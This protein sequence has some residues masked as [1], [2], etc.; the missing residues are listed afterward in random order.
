[1]AISNQLVQNQN[2]GART[3]S[4]YLTGEKVQKSLVSTLGS[5]K[6]MQK[7]VSSI[8]AAASANTALQNCDY[9]TVVSA[10][11]LATAL[12][13][14]LSPS[15]GLAYIVPFDDKKN[16]RTV[17]TFILGYRGYLQLAIRSGYYADID[18]TE[19]RRG[20]YLGRDSATGKPRFKFIEDDD[21]REKLPVVGYMAYYRYLNGFEKTIYWS[22]TKMLSHADTYS[23]AFSLEGKNGKMSFA[24]FEAG[25]VPADQLWKYSS[26]WYKDFDGMAKKTMIR[27][28][29]SKWGIMSIDMQK[30]YD[31]DTKAIDK[32]ND[33]FV[34]NGEADASDSFFGN[35]GGEYLD[36][37]PAAEIAEEAKTEIKTTRGR[38][39]PVLDVEPDGFF[40]E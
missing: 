27:Q 39:K 5:E 10:A 23:K 21:E 19:I 31:E 17:G 6:E 34:S 24:D 9:S 28:L 29:I 37:A 4:A 26:Y 18:V 30:A 38:K 12:N 33:L 7:F 40:T 13:L 15:L 14:S 1:M 36:E 2:G 8:V 32:E 35:T 22:K 11:L 20:E 3:L 16:N 25:K